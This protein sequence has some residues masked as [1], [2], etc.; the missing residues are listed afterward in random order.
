MSEPSKDVSCNLAY[1]YAHPTPA[2][3]KGKDSHRKYTYAV[4][5]AL[6]ELI[7]GV[8]AFISTRSYLQKNETDTTVW[9]ALTLFSAFLS[10]KYVHWREETPKAI[11]VAQ[12]VED[13][14]Y[15][16]ETGVTI[17][18]YYFTNMDEAIE[19]QRCH[20]FLIGRQVVETEQF[21]LWANSTLNNPMH[22]QYYNRM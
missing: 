20:L 9:G 11:T 14:A 2:H 6:C 13:T 22:W 19:A 5:G 7:A 12:D 8:S 3:I 17:G 10:R 21:F 1:L 15:S 18:N 4:L 16:P